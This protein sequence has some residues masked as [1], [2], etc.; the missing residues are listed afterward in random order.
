MRRVHLLTVAL[1]VMGVD[2]GSKALVADRWPERVLYHVGSPFGPVHVLALSCGVTFVLLRSE[3]VRGPWAAIALGGVLGNGVELLIGAGVI[4][5][6][7]V[8]DYRVNLA[9]L[10]IGVGVVGAFVVTGSRLT[11]QLRGLRARL[12]LVAWTVGASMA[13]ALVVHVR[14][15]QGSAVAADDRAAHLACE[16]AAYAPMR[17]VRDDVPADGEAVVG[18]TA[19][20]VTR[21]ER[22]DTPHGRCVRVTASADEIPTL[23]VAGY[24]RPSSGSQIALVTRG[25]WARETTVT[26]A[27]ERHRGGFGVFVA[28]VG[29]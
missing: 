8:S 29:R 25:P 3:A 6:I 17:L 15:E 16:R 7:P 23:F 22:A 21:V 2:L 27:F 26:Q 11:G 13:F 14:S 9:D 19:R 1:V 20:T 24:G 18:R 4:D 28:A 5:W 10:A 12:L